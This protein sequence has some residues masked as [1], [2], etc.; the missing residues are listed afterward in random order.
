MKTAALALLLA[1]LSTSGSSGGSKKNVPPVSVPAVASAPAKPDPQQAA[2]ERT[3]EA[4]REVLHDS[5]YRFCHSDE[6]VLFPHE[7]EW[8]ADVG[9]SNSACP[10]LPAACLGKPKP[11]G[12]SKHEVP[13][14]PAPP[15]VL[16]PILETL[17]WALVIA[18]VAALAWVIF[19]YAIASP[20]ES[21][22]E[23]KGD[24]DDDAAK[25]AAAIVAKQIET[26]VQR[27]LA[28]ARR[29]AEAGNFAEALHHA[30]AALI[31][32]LEG[33]GLIRVHPSRTNGDFLMDLAA[34]PELRAEVRQVV[35]AVEGVEFGSQPP[36]RAIFDSV[37]E[38]VGGLI[39]RKLAK[40]LLLVLLTGLAFSCDVL[41]RG[42]S[43]DTPGG[44][45]GVIDV[46]NRR[47]A[48][49]KVRLQS[50][51]KELH[52]DATLVLM[53]DAPA[54]SKENLG[55][56]QDWVFNGGT[57]ILTGHRS[58]QK[59]LYQAIGVD[60]DVVQAARPLRVGAAFRPQIGDVQVKVPAGVL[61]KLTDVSSA[62]AP[63]NAV[64]CPGS[65]R[66]RGLL[67]QRTV[68]LDADGKPYAVA[69]DVRRPI[70]EDAEED[71]GRIILFA[72]DRLFSN[73]ALAVGDNAHFLVGLLGESDVEFVNELTGASA[74]TPVSSIRHSGLLPFLLQLG[75]LVLLFLFCQGVR[76]G[77]ARDP[78][79]RRRRAFADHVRALGAVYAKAQAARHALASYSAFAYERLRERLQLRGRRGF[80]LMAESLAARTGRPLAEVARVL[81]ETYELRANDNDDRS[82]AA[83]AQ[84]LQLMKELEALMRAQRRRGP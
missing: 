57:L 65:E 66:V 55:T 47:G 73:I 74:D 83:V 49:A 3:R 2:R 1:L 46:L 84:D 27:L 5:R 19:K 52:D 6:Y 42:D 34:Q 12:C 7:K 68:L 78:E 9:S 44:T 29:S 58:D 31:R 25:T 75:A 71:G 64:V 8:C 69:V 43:E 37:Y 4:T 62:K 38:Q 14:V 70:P 36:S 15:S 39:S 79:L 81:A 23:D 50:L 20:E 45:H 18:A 17:F 10:Q 28:L 56:L 13:D 67:K 16:S 76:F 21:P 77:T 30:H 41:N 53:P 33:D 61:L 72:D 60:D 63:D 40:V 48:H 80:H 22:A 35:R 32:R 54:L 26:D 59:C 24:N 51:S 82:P 11:S